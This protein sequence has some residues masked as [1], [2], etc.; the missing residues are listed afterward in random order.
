[1]SAP[2]RVV[3]GLLA[4]ALLS[5]G[6]ASLANPAA[7]AELQEALLDL[8]ELLGQMREETAMLQWQVDSL[9]G[10]VARQDSSLRR[11]ANLLGMPLSP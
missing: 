9:Q 4:I 3:T 10:V 7:S 11:L 2:F 5:A 6:C 1:M 8:Q